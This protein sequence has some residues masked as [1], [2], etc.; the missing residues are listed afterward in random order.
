M[1]RKWP[2][3]RA[4]AR[5]G[6]SCGRGLPMLRRLCRCCLRQCNRSYLNL[7]T[8]L[9]TE[10]P[11]R[12]HLGPRSSPVSSAQ[13]GTIRSARAQRRV[14]EESGA[15][16]AR[17]LGQAPTVSAAAP[18]EELAKQKTHLG[19]RSAARRAPGAASAAG[20]SSRPM[21]GAL[22]LPLCTVSVQPF[23]GQN[24]ELCSLG[25]APKECN[26]LSRSRPKEAAS[27][28]PRASS[29]HIVCVAG[30][31]GSVS[32]V[33]PPSGERSRWPSPRHVDRQA[34]HWRESTVPLS[35]AEQ[36][37]RLRVGT[38]LARQLPPRRD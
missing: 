33:G 13:T 35:A 12:T 20:H 4:D 37:R 22:A 6:A 36:L 10:Q 14:S 30:G 34:L 29:G 2:L 8:H 1:Q 21:P 25:R 32:G 11:A 23:V 28:C 7:I 26:T 24:L 5:G 9:N 31:P 19:P 16:S 18:K 27:R 3:Q 38:L 17:Q 15:S